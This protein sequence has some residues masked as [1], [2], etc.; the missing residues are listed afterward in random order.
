MKKGDKAKL[1]GTDFEFTITG[2]DVIN[3]NEMVC[4]DFGDFNKDLVE[5]ITNIEQ[6]GNKT[7]IKNRFL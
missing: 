7:N 1:K 3:D 5:L 4:S 6:D 2:F